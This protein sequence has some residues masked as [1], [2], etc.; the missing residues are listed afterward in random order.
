[1]D[2]DVDVDVDGDE[3]GDEDAVAPRGRLETPCES[4]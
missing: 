4:C 1:V 2:G 3:D